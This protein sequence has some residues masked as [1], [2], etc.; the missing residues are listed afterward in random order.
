LRCHATWPVDE[1]EPPVELK[2]G[3]SCQACHGP[4]FDWSRPH[5]EKWWRLCTPEAKQ[6][7]GMVNLRDPVRRTQLCV[8]CHIGDRAQDRFVTHAMYAAGHPPLPSF[9]FGAF[10]EQMPAHWRPL[11]EKAG[12]PGRDSDAG[13]DRRDGFNE[14]FQIRA[15]DMRA[16]YLLANQ[17]HLPPHAT[18]DV[19]RTRDTVIGAL[20]VLS[21]FTRMIGESN[22][23]LQS[24]AG[25]IPDFAL[26]DCTGCHHEL[27]FEAGR[28]VVD[29][30]GIRPGRPALPLWP[31][32]LARQALELLPPDKS[33]GDRDGLEFVARWRELRTAVARR[34]F[35]SP[36]EVA[37]AAEQLSRW[38]VQRIEES[39]RRSM[40]SVDTR[41]FLLSLTESDRDPAIVSDFASARQ[42]AWA[43]RE[44]AA[45]LNWPLQQR[46]EL[47]LTDES[48]DL[49]R[50]RLPSGQL[51]QIVEA[52]PD[53]LQAQR[54]YQ[55]SW[56]RDALQR[57]RG[58]LREGKREE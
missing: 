30:R 14:R 23:E 57:T 13:I 46:Q 1:P 33:Q 43:I 36:A 49:L 54:N 21:E 22:A 25:A 9:E 52:V 53:L 10:R 38:T 26:F 31:M 3:V 58:Q 12:F 45:D 11:A 17:G 5:R 39:G 19:A 51:Q 18:R 27:R 24:T 47:F 29:V 15:D 56:F 37:T 4:G 28:P 35:G 40:S 50:L 20:V 44:V 32:A 34:P 7:L 42:I 48:I 41:R 6:R 16:S 8:S 55:A 2:F